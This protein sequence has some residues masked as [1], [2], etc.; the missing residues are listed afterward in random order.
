M[1]FT[2]LPFDDFKCC[3]AVLCLRLVGSCGGLRI[4]C[5]SCYMTVKVTW[6]LKLQTVYNCP[7]YEMCLWKRTDLCNLY[8]YL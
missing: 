7:Y 5:D 1:G 8:I 2:S 6:H 3:N 4:M